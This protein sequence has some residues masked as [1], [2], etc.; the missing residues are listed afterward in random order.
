MAARPILLTVAMLSRAAIVRQQLST[1]FS[2][3]MA[4]G[5]HQ[6]EEMV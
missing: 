2:D 1:T 3:A 4:A 5:A 6:Q